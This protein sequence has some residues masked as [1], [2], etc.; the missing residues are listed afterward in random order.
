M[1]F[2]NAIDKMP[3]YMRRLMA[4]DLVPM[5]G[6]SLEVRKGVYVLYYEGRP[7]YV[8]RSR[9]MKQRLRMHVSGGKEG[10]SFAFKLGRRLLQTQEPRRISATRKQLAAD[11]DFQRAFD[12]AVARI[13]EM[14]VRAVEVDDPIEQT[15]F[16]IYAHMELRT[17]FNSF[18][19]S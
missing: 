17:R 10:A 15:L 8:G 1:T 3:R 4:C 6:N 11:P 16:E 2:R 14:E 19:T 5:P 12:L 18:E 9:N 7:V 13:R